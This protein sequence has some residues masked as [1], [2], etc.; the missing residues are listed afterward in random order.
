MIKIICLFFPAFISL[1][2]SERI[3]KKKNKKKEN[4]EKINTYVFYNILINMITLLFICYLNDFE[5]VMFDD[6]A[7]TMVFSLEYLTLATAL[8]LILPYASNYIKNNFKIEL[9]RE[10]RK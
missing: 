9:K 6:T 2:G 8:A 1:S 7:F 10:K 5:V 4:L 3:D